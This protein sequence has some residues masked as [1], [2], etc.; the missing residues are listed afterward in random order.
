M[1]KSQNKQFTRIHLN[2]PTREEVLALHQKYSFHE[3]IL[4]D[5]LE[6]N[7]ENKVEYFEE[8]E[9]LAI[10]VNFP[11]YKQALHKHLLNALAIII[12]DGVILS[13]SRF[14]S[15]NLEKSITL[16]NKEDY[17]IKNGI[18]NTFD[19]MYEIFDIMYDKTLRWM[20]KSNRE[21]LKLQESIMYSNTLSKKLIEELMTKKVNMIVLQHTFRPQREILHEIKRNLKKIYQQDSIDVEELKLY[22]DDLDAKLDKIINTISVSFETIRSLTD[23]YNSLMTIKT[24]TIITTLTICTVVTGLMAVIVWAYGMNVA[25]PFADSPYA[26]IW[27]IGSMIIL[28]L[29]TI[30]LFKKKW[31]L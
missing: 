12:I 21:I 18:K 11:K 24:N 1:L 28:L 27:I 7:S 31:W 19:V 29:I 6:M 25:L 5:L 30:L 9:T 2:A 23:T 22:V 10:M 15:K 8:E 20:S 13:V 16:M 26:F 17:R 14:S 4:E 3:L